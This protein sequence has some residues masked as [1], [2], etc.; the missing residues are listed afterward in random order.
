MF[1]MKSRGKLIVLTAATLSLCVI[2]LFSLYGKKPKMTPEELI[3]KHLNSI[4]DA[5]T[6]GTIQTRLLQGQGR[7]IQVQGSGSGS[8]I[9]DLNGPAMWASAGK[10][11]RLWFGFDHPSYAADDV[12]FDGKNLEAS[13]P[14]PGGSGRSLLGDFL[15]TYKIAIKEGLLGGALS[16]NWA[17]TNIEELKPKL[18]FSGLTKLG[19]GKFLTL[20]YQPRRGAQ[21]VK[22]RLF[23]HP[24]TFAHVATMYEVK[25][26]GQMGGTLEQSA[27]SNRDT[28]YTLMETF[29][30]HQEIDGLTLPTRWSLRVALIGPEDGATWEWRL[31]ATGV[32]HNQELGTDYF[33]DLRTVPGPN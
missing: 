8:G 26:P 7:V 31:Q 18:K 19:T 9:V 3:E 16:T 12:I 29:D 6:R 15:Y 17:L 14:Q 21:G 28:Y 20:R 22:I 5:D 10:N 11:C 33:A 25:L 27:Q 1:S 13:R 30:G 23:F 24:E 2:P 32:A 4:A